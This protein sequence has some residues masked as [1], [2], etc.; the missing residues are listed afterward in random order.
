MVMPWYN[1]FYGSAQV[2]SQPQIGGLAVFQMTVKNYLLI[3]DAHDSKQLPYLMSC[4]GHDGYI[5][6]NGLPDPKAFY[7]DAIAHFDDYF[8]LQSSVL[9]QRKQFFE[10]WQEPNENIM[11]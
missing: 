6:Y 5:I 4:L 1:V 8:K 7:T 10:A 2:A 11:E 9:L 3:V